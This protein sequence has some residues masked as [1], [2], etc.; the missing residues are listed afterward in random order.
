[1]RIQGRQ[2]IILFLCFFAFSTCKKA[3]T[4]QPAETP[5][6]AVK[7]VVPTA[8][9][10]QQV[11]RDMMLEKAAAAIVDLYTNAS[12]AM[13]ADSATVAFVSTR[14]GL[15][16]VYVAPAGK[17]DKEPLRLS[18]M[19]E[20]ARY[21]VFTPDGTNVLYLSDVGAN[22]QYRIYS[23]PAAG[24]EP[25]CLTPEGDLQR[26]P[27]IVTADGSTMFY[28]AALLEETRTILFSQGLAAESPKEIVSMPRRALL[29]DISHDGSVALLLA[30]KSFSE[31]EVFVVDTAQGHSRL[32]YPP[33][34]QAHAVFAA[35]LSAD[36]S[37]VFVSTDLGNDEAYILKLET[38]TGKKKAMYREANQPRGVFH[39][40]LVAAE[41]SRLLAV[42]HAGDHSELRLMNAQTLGLLDTPDIPLGAIT[43]GRCEKASGKCPL[44]LSTVD[45]PT[46]IHA[47][48]F[49]KSTLTPLLSEARPELENLPKVHVQIVSIPSTDGIN[50]PA[51][52]YLPQNL[53]PGTRLPVIVDMH[54]GPASSSM[55]SWDPFAT[56]FISQ[57]YAVV[58]PNVRGSAGFGRSYEQAD[59]VK[60]RMKSVEDM[61]MVGQWVSNQYWADAKRL[62]VFGGSYGGYMVLMGLAFQPFT[63]AAGIDLVGVS[64]LVTLV[65]TTMGSL[66][67][68]AVAEF[69][70]PE[71][72][73]TFLESVSPLNHAG[74]IADPLFVYQGRNDPRVPRSESDQI[75]GALQ[76]KGIKVE[77]MIMEKE[78][79]SVDRR[80]SKLE[81]L[82]RSA[83]FLEEVLGLGPQPAPAQAPA[84]APA[85]APAP[86]QP[87]APA[88][89][90]QPAG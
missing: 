13:S 86:G 35:A 70:D 84:P 28:T 58:Q 63:W 62:V 29:Q 27:P 72:D 9:T 37:E 43:S 24:G 11:T 38:A 2:L 6:V 20:R 46:D 1:M 36:G 65:K 33:Q 25:A 54:G 3:G 18:K 52:V 60:S 87:P 61:G 26:G 59:N 10:P 40:F 85:T 68:L 44:T 45:R 81:F 5:T 83:R 51:N 22:E 8:R 34:G 21:P 90:P 75:V 57:G 55:V 69:G 71:S 78:G 88:P 47:I 14:E 41:G 76:A 49:K 42:L 79:H 64:S 17:T 50:V 89:Q 66:R 4:A 15:S 39:D 31:M 16:Q 77:Y 74:K 32:L 19:E 56:F 80:E 82:S 12:P 73:R 30:V 48:D 7:D 23:A 53:P 67:E